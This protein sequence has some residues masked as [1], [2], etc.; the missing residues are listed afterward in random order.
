MLKTAQSIRYLARQGLPL[1][2]EVDSNFNQLLLH[3]EIDD[4]RI[5]SY[6]RKKTEDFVCI[7]KVESIEANVIVGVLKQVL[8]K[9]IK[10][11]LTDCLVQCYDRAANMAD[12]C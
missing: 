1:R 10:L 6:L 12:R 4:L 9:D 3:R 8:K 2:A 7:E 11:L 5:L